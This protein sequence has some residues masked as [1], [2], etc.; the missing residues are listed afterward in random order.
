MSKFKL[1]I[2]IA[3]KA[4]LVKAQ[5]TT[6]KAGGEIAVLTV[7]G[8]DNRV[9]AIKC[10]PNFLRHALG[11]PEDTTVEDAVA[12][13]H[14][15]VGEYA[16][17]HVNQNI[18]GITCYIDDKGKEVAHSKDGY[19]LQMIGLLKEQQQTMLINFELADSIGITVN[20]D[21]FL[22]MLSARALP[23]INVED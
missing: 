15:L 14:D 16:E 2:L 20:E 10:A 11:M 17:F 3:L 22:R 19:S 6:L 18:A 9:H 8:T 4:R 23:Q 13:L 7:V 21:S 5:I 12:R 1:P